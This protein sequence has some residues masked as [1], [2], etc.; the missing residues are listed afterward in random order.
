MKIIRLTD[1]GK[2]TAAAISPDGNYVCMLDRTKE[3]RAFV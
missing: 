3:S 1:S 2:A